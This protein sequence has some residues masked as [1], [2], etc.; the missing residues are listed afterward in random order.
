MSK[1]KEYLGDGVYADVENGLLKLTTEDGVSAY[2]TIFLDAPV[3]KALTCFWKK[4]NT[5]APPTPETVGSEAPSTL[6]TK[7]GKKLN[8]TTDWRNHKWQH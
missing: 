5:R 3:Y 2:N 1:S 7:G 6:L 8:S 4:A